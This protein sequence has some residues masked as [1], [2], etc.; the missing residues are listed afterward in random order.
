MSEK[1]SAGCEMVNPREVVFK[2]SRVWNGVLDAFS[3]CF[4]QEI[5]LCV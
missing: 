2:D 3:S 1:M 4:A 5:S